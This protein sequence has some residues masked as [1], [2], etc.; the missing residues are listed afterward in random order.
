MM[1]EDLVRKREKNC[2]SFIEKYFFNCAELSN[3]KLKP[4]RQC[5]RQVFMF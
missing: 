5:D 3:L 1:K 2:A 4:E